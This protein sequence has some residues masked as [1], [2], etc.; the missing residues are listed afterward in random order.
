MSIYYKCNVFR[1]NPNKLF[2]NKIHKRAS[3]TKDFDSLGYPDASYAFSKVG[4]IAITRIQQKMLSLD[5]RPDLVINAVCPGY[6]ITDMTQ[7]TGY[8]TPDQGL[9]KRERVFKP[10]FYL[11]EIKLC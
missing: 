1:S 3:K 5:S 10:F 7:N 11:Q 2:K 4:L 9:K 8:V 6:T